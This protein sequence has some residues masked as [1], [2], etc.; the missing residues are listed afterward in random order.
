MVGIARQK[1][2]S[3]QQRAVG[4]SSGVGI[5]TLVPTALPLVVAITV[6][7]TVGA[8]AFTHGDAAADLKDAG[9]DDDLAAAVGRAAAEEE[10]R[11]RLDKLNLLWTAA[12]KRAHLEKVGA[13]VVATARKRGAGSP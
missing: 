12:Q 10:R 8:F 11:F 3:D 7:G 9:L 6:V 4:R 1:K 5:A 13:R 2:C